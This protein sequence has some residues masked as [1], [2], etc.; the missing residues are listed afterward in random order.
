M[1]CHSQDLYVDLFYFLFVKQSR[2]PLNSTS[3][4]IYL[5]ILCGNYLTCTL[6]VGQPKGGLPITTLI[7][8]FVYVLQ[9]DTYA[10]LLTA[11]LAT[12]TELL[13]VL[14][15]NKMPPLAGDRKLIKCHIW[16]IEN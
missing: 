1:R 6:L 15:I 11:T 7:E 13:N 8:S 9:S 16:V 3:T 4:N 5:R 10:A 12:R 2:Q 14:K